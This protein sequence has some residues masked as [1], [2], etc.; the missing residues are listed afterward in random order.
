MHDLSR[1]LTLTDA[2]YGKEGIR[3]LIAAR[4]QDAPD[5]VRDCSFRIMVRGRFDA[6]YLNGENAAILPSD[7]LRRHVLASGADDGDRSLEAICHGAAERVL[8]ANPEIESVRVEAT[9]RRWR[10]VGT[11]SFTAAE[12]PLRATCECSRDGEPALSGGVEA[13]DVLV[14]SGSDFTGF[15]RDA[16]TV[17]PEARDRPL[18]GTISAE[19][20]FSG[21][22]PARE[23]ST[24]I[25]TALLGA[26]A[27]RPSNA[28]QQWI[29]AAA[30]AVLD[31]TQALSSLAVRFISLP[32]VPLPEA[33]AAA[34]A[35]G[36]RA[37]E[38]GGGPAG[39]TDVRLNR[40]SASRS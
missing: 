14:T 10:A 26:L 3:L 11:H 13:L 23:G 27:D 30:A 40:A 16:L 34:A 1:R 18:A 6:S 36:L 32:I 7:T 24:A 8:A 31:A 15:R 20:T 33:L 35:T 21:G 19:W 5:A 29:T 37:Y 9:E 39:V 28:V 2:A 17:Q 4:R 25:A 12:T 38:L 22:P